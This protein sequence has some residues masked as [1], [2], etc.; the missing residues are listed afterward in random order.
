MSD[1]FAKWVRWFSAFYTFTTCTIS[2]TQDSQS[3]ILDMFHYSM[4][5][6]LLN[7]CSVSHFAGV[8]Y[9]GFN[10]SRMIKVAQSHAYSVVNG[11]A[12]FNVYAKLSKQVLAFFFVEFWL[13]ES[14][15]RYRSTIADKHKRGWKG[16]SLCLQ[17]PTHE[18]AARA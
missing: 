18:Q 11:F 17:E 2:I 3:V 1:L 10:Q 14:A 4:W 12:I 9:I 16:D 6:P 5:R 13:L 8:V 7:S 15:N